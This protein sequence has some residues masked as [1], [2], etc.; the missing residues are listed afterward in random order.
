MKGKI[1]HQGDISGLFGSARVLISCGAGGVGK[2]TIAAS[3]GLLAAERHG[4]KVLVLTID[5]AKRLASA[6]GLSEVGN[7]AVEVVGV[8]G[9]WAAMLDT[10]SSWDDLVRR[11][12]PDVE[13]ERKILANPLY[14]NIT[15]RFTQAHD[16]I[17]MERLYE[18]VESN[19]YDL[20]V[21]DTPPSRNALDFLDAPQRMAEFFTSPLLRWITLPYRIGGERAGRLGYLAA[22]PFY[23]VA[24]RILGSQFLQD[25][26]EFFL[27]FQSMYGGFVRRAE[28][29]RAVLHEPSTSF[30]VVTSPETAAVREAEFFLSELESRGLAVGALV[31]NRV[32]PQ[33]L[34]DP[35][36]RALGVRV[37][38][39]GLGS[40]TGSGLSVREQRVLELASESYGRIAALAEAHHTTLERIAMRPPVACTVPVEVG[41]L[42][43]LS[44]LRRI[45]AALAADSGTLF[46][47]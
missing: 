47:G 21:V 11:H 19:E 4:A 18:V 31:M 44:G 17:A 5:P 29:V 14:R 7:V 13:T 42:T 22:K 43:D 33:A 1:Q 41:D 23:Q 32:L 45:G 6:M 20:V 34:T 12:A 8:P 27:L 2:T 10:S 46:R 39:E 25:V 28:A 37:V 16:Y 15:Q 30:V 3:L 9:M 35:Q 40:A 36:A 38:S 24:D 26:A